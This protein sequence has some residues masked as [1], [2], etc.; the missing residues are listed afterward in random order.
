MEKIMI[1]LLKCFLEVTPKSFEVSGLLDAS[2][3]ANY[4]NLSWV[5]DNITHGSFVIS[6]PYKNVLIYTPPANDGSARLY[7]DDIRA[8]DKGSN[9]AVNVSIHVRPPK[10]I[11][12]FI[13]DAS[14]PDPIVNFAFENLQENGLGTPWMKNLQ[15]VKAPSEG[16]K[17]TLGS[18]VITFSNQSPQDTNC[19][20]DNKA[21][22]PVSPTVFATV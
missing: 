12:Q 21:V 22:L 11:N 19:S 3:Q 6:G 9:Q 14:A 17:L 7:I 18:C 13:A 8:I 5:T 20:G 4:S 10:I 2:G 1:S 16:D 15:W